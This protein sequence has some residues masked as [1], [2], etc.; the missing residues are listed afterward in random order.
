MIMKKVTLFLMMALTFTLVV[1]CASTSDVENLQSQ[2]N[3]LNTSVNQASASAA[4]AQTMAANAAAKAEAAE[5]AAN[6]AAEL[7]QETND[8]LDRKFKGSMMK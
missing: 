5:T 1:G 6:R 2:V 8:R 4:N 7:S 3:S